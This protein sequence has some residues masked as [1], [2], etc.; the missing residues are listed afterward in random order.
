VGYLK[1]QD[2]FFVVMGWVLAVL[3]FVGM[4][5]GL[6]LIGAGLA[7]GAH[8]GWAEL[9]QRARRFLRDHHR[10]PNDGI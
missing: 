1:A 9:P 2:G 6:L 4:F 5:V 10:S 7:L 8:P 3:A